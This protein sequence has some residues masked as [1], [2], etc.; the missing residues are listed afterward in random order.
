MNWFAGL[1]N[2]L[3]KIAIIC[4]NEAS[5]CDRYGTEQSPTDYINQM[6]TKAK[7]T[8]NQKYVITYDLE[9]G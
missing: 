9:L 7:Q 4:A 6:L 3:Q 1:T 8:V 2:D 5:L